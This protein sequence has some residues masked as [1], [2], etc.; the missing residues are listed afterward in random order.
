MRSPPHSK[1]RIYHKQRLQARNQTYTVTNYLQGSIWASAKT[2]QAKDQETLPVFPD[3][4]K[5]TG[6]NANH[7]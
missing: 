3:F 7:S 4:Q 5:K 6:K 2:V 1:S